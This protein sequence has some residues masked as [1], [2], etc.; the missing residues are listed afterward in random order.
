M[1]LERN[2]RL[3]FILFLVFLCNQIVA[4]E[5]VMLLTSGWKFRKANSTEKWLPASIPGN[6]YSD[7]L[8][9]KLI[10][11]PYIGCNSM[12]LKWV[13]ECDWEYQTVFTINT[14][15]FLRSE[16][17]LEF[18]GLDTYAKVYL[19]DSLVLTADNMFR[20][21]K[22]NSTKYVRN[23]GNTLRVV[24]SSAQK[25]V[26]EQS[27]KLAYK[28]PGGDWAYIRKAAYQ[29]G[30]DW[31][32]TLKSCGI[33]K[34]VYLRTKP[35]FTIE[36]FYYKTIE[37]SESK[38]II[39]ANFEVNS[40]YKQKISVELTDSK[41]RTSISEKKE[42]VKSGKTL[43]QTRFTIEK[44]KL[45]WPSGM[46]SQYQYALSCRIL[47]KDGKLVVIDK[48]LG[49]KT[50]EVVNKPDS[51]G[52][53]FYFK[54]NSKPLFAKGANIV[55]PNSLISAVRDN[56]WIALADNALKCNMNML[57]VW[58]GGIYPP[59]AFYEACSKKGILVWQDFMFACSMYPWD[60]LFIKNVEIEATEQVQRLRGFPCIALWCGNNEVDEGWHNWGW[61]KQ[62]DT[63][64]NATATIWN[65]YKKLF[66]ETLP[67]IVNT[68]DPEKFYWASSP[69][70]GWGKKESMKSGDSHYWGVWW[71]GEPFSVF[72][73]KV[74][75]F[76]SEYGF[77][78]F[79]DAR[80]LQAFSKDGNAKP[81]SLGLLCHQKHP[82]GYQTIDKFTKCEAFNP[83][84]L[85]DS[86]YFS[87][88]LQAIGYRTAIESQRIAMPRCMGTLYWQMNDSWPGV[89]WSGIDFYGRWKAVQ[90][91][92]RNAYKPILISAE[93]N[94]HEIT[95]KVVSDFQ[96]PTEGEL[97]VLLYNLNGDI[98]K[99]WVNPATIKP[100][101][102]EQLLRVNNE[103]NQ[104]DSCNIFIYA[105]F[106]S[107]AGESYFTYSY[108]CKQGNLMLLNP[109][110]K[111]KTEKVL[112][113]YT[114]ILTALHPTFN[115]QILSAAP[116]FKVENNYFNLLPG[117]EYR[118]RIL[119]GN[120]KEIEVKSLYDYLHN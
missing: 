74:P 99:R 21:W 51:I 12:N 62:V 80:T 113:E 95:V 85:A 36:N 35:D 89:S 65:G 8:A 33:W 116:D 90:Y 76:M 86:I 44:P 31:A 5:G 104:A 49:L 102:S 45:W 16:T 67:S 19:N 109:E 92:V 29:F 87:Q 23:G 61:T 77:Q 73:T 63:I 83:K 1:E 108:N 107:Q 119:S 30:W 115:V 98:I 40:P 56:E 39:E 20:S 25:Y 96:I 41:T 70:F 58:G 84:T 10:L 93:S 105:E 91:A 71:G 38:A 27:T 46:G 3:V 14:D 68:Y 120:D 117:K 13:D 52:N 28:L 59:D 6:I 103:L 2:K 101:V 15:M 53:S 32:P 55:P 11:D 54:V 106:L 9:N 79:P 17:E 37:L 110:I 57:R 94:G 64:P 26:D 43:I 18:K 88:I 112:E 114:L 78:G 34:K 118:V 75:R 82:V 66:N 42:E 111:V 47:N 97:K 7:L 60:S 69:Q 81:D 48:E 72:K 50:I 22:V 100:N 4:Q 24:F